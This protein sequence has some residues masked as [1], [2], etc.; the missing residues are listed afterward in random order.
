MK[1]KE[2]AADVQS[3]AFNP[4]YFTIHNLEELTRYSDIYYQFR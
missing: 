3:Q 1:I 2:N 4:I